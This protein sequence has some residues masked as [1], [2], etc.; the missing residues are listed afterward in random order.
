[1]ERRTFI[2][3]M[4]AGSTAGRAL[5]GDAPSAGS[6]G[7]S[8]PNFLFMIA[9]DLTY[10]AIGALYGQGVRTPN[11]DRLVTGGCAFTH[12]FEQ[13]SWTPAVCIASRMML[14][15]GLNTFRA[16]QECDFTPLVGT[17][18]SQCRLPHVYRREMASGPYDDAAML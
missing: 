4:V 10:R 3:S 16:D 11:L 6:A 14:V 8:Q 18:A 1:M 7:K 12:C 17:D 13:G 5:A 15:T 2:K 9:D